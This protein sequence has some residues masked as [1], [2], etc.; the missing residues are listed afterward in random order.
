VGDVERFELTAVFEPVEEGWVQGTIAELPGVI[1]AG[2]TIEEAKTL[3][4]DALREY[5]LAIRE[6]A[7]AVPP[8]AERAALSV[9]VDL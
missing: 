3:L 9:S 7:G 4:L 1:T 8:G 2:P 6:T 5:F